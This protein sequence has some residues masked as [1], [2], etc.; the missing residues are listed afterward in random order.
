MGRCGGGGDGSEGGGR[1][2]VHTTHPCR[3]CGKG[4][5]KRLGV[6]VNI[7]EGKID[8]IPLCEDCFYRYDVKRGKQGYRFERKKAVSR[9]AWV[10]LALESVRGAKAVERLAAGPLGRLL[11]SRAVT[12]LGLIGVALALILLATPL[13]RYVLN[14]RLLDS[15]RSFFAEHPLHGALMVPGIDPMIPLIQGWLALIASLSIHEISHAVAAA[16]LGA[17][18]PRAIG[19]LLLGPIPVAGYVDIN[20]IFIKSRK[21]LYV[22]AAGIGSNILLS[23]VCWLI[24]SVYALLRGFS[25]GLYVFFPPELLSLL[26]VTSPFNDLV[27]GTICWVAFLSFWLAMFNALPILGLDGYYI[28]AGIL[29]R[30]VGAEKAFNITKL[31]GLLVTGLLVF[32][33]LAQRIPTHL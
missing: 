27:A 5:V 3:I 28:L 13:I 10:F 20:P 19:I 29:S 24:L 17:G 14:P 21:E 7:L 6:P 26:G 25:I 23:L 2:A 11:A 9:K 18:E 8:E 4:A 22:M 1:E 32:L 15:A 33:T 30:L 16:R 12:I 31:T